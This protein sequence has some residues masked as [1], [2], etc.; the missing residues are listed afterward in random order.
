M[1]RSL[2]THRTK[3]NTGFCAFQVARSHGRAPNGEQQRLQGGVG[4][5]WQ[6]GLGEL[7]KLCVT[8]RKRGFHA[9][10][11]GGRFAL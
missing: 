1:G 6:L 9:Q 7:A 10:G 8:M 4:G 5:S 11:R 3:L 2:V